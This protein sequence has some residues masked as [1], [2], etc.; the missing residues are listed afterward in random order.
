MC[1]ALEQVISLRRNM[2]LRRVIISAIRRESY[3]WHTSDLTL[4]MRKWREFVRKSVEDET[5]SMEISRMS[6]AP[7]M[8]PNGPRSIASGLDESLRDIDK[9]CEG[10]EEGLGTSSLPRSPTAE[11]NFIMRRLWDPSEGEGGATQ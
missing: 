6:S 2:K 11:D 3:A 4:A 5:S 7:P 1:G 10:H 9:G 8:T